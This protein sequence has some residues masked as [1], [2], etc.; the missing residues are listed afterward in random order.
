MKQDVLSV[1]DVKI[2]EILEAQGAPSYRRGQ[3][4]DAIYRVNTIKLFSQ[5]PNI[6]RDLRQK[7]STTLGDSILTLDLAKAQVSDT[8][9]KVLFK[10]RDNLFIETVKM[11]YESGRTTYC[12]SL[13][14]GCAMGCAFCATGKSGFT[15]NLVVEE[16]VDQ[17]LFFKKRGDP[18]D[19]IVFMGMGEP[20]ANPATFE[21]LNI[22][23]D[24]HKFGIGQRHISVS[25]VGLVPG[26][27]RMTEE[28][29]Q[30]N[31]A[32]SLHSPYE[33]ERRQLMPI[34]K[35][36]PIQDV[37]SALRTHILRTH[38]KVLIAY[39]LLKDVNDSVDHARALADLLNS[40]EDVKGLFHVNLINMHEVAGIQF[41]RT[42]SERLEAFR[43]IL[44]KWGIRTTVRQ[45]FGEDI[46]AACGQLRGKR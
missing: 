19:N 6:P 36:F 9:E 4:L 43:A 18:I 38:R 45:D 35:T 1:R 22:F 27:R 7:L 28:H 15:R 12:V 24:P 17:V 33:T 14:V 5:I 13:Q 32:F 21:A 11:Q 8:T 44:H 31:L 34:S 20:L 23:T 2:L 25:T 29:P 30:I 42:S 46:D 41:K 3:V 37:M 40:H 10:T 26:I 39:I 16:I